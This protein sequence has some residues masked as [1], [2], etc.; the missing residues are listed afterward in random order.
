MWRCEQSH[1]LWTRLKWPIFIFPSSKLTVNFSPLKIPQH[2]K[3]V[4]TLPCEICTCVTFASHYWPRLVFCATPCTCLHCMRGPMCYSQEVVRLF[5]RANK[6]HSEVSRWLDGIVN[7]SKRY[8]SR[9]VAHRPLQSI[10]LTS[11]NI[12]MPSLGQSTFC[13]SA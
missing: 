7:R 11:S 12:L 1:V 3:R 2:V 13:I 5:G 10:G 8:E 4:A 9:P 6:W